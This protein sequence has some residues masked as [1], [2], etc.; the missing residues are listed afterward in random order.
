MSCRDLV[1]Y[2]AS[3]TVRLEPYIK[4]FVR[5]GMFLRGL[6]LPLQQWATSSREG[7]APVN[8]N[9]TLSTQCLMLSKV[10]VR[11]A[12]W[13]I[14]LAYRNSSENADGSMLSYLANILDFLAA[15]RRTRMSSNDSTI[16]FS[17]I[18]SKI[19][20][21]DSFYSSSFAV[22]YVVIVLGICCFEELKVP[23][24]FSRC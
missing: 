22:S 24:T 8:T 13:Q 7:L 19:Y 11:V 10:T 1:T 4:A 6:S 5:A 20:L 12:F 17:C 16:V 21:I 2:R 18:F 3:D 9:N 23:I 14:F 15:C